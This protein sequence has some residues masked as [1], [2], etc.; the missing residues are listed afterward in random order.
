MSDLTD[1]E[2][3]KLLG[4]AE[5]EAAERELVDVAGASGA[6]FQVMN[7][8]EKAWFEAT[9]QLYLDQYK[10]SNVSDLQD[11]DRLLGLEL[12]SYRYS[13]WLI[14][15]TDYDGLSFDE[16]AVRNHKQK[17]D[18]E[19]R[20]IKTH[21]GMGRKHRVE[22]E[23]QSTAEYLK[24]L[25]RRAEEFGVHRNMQ[26]AKAMDLFNDL[27]ALVGL[28]DRTDEEEAAHL[29]VGTDDILNWIRDIAIPEYDAIDDAFRK[30]QRLWI[31]EV[32]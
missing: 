20:L 10:F 32:S 31:R 28:H 21:M 30:E 13:N 11:I 9:M 1:G 3:K 5:E 22:S 27:K 23:Q 4:D 2:I 29:G 14:R 7:H 15:E 12:L 24:N 18:Q 17:I 25:L 19:I 6:E 26:V 16:Q 8:D